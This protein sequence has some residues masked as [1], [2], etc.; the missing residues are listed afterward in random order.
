MFLI[1]EVCCPLPDYTPAM[2]GGSLQR[3]DLIAEYFAQGFTYKDILVAL[4][5]SHGIAISLK[6]LKRT[7]RSLRLRR[8]QFLSREEIVSAIDEI[9]TELS[10][11]GQCIGYRSMWK[12]LQNKGLVV[13]AH[14]VREILKFLD[15]EGV[16]GR[17]IGRLKRRDY[18]NPG[19]N[20][21]WHI[22][23]YD[24]LKPFG[25][26][27]HGAIDGYSRRILWVELGISN[28]NPKVILKYFVD[29]IKKLKTIPCIIRSDRGT[30]NIHVQD[31]QQTLRAHDGDEFCNK[32]F[33]YGKSSSNQRIEAWWRILRQQSMG[34]Y[35][36]LF[37]DMVCQGI[38]DTGNQL[39][40]HSLRFAFWD[41]I[42]SDLNR[43]AIEWNRHRLQ[44][45]K[46]TKELRV[47]PTC[48]TL[49]LKLIRQQ[50]VVF[51]AIQT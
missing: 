26:A 38:L 44:V 39:H 36:N 45:K 34:F 22:D 51:F 47:F 32:A 13:S 46:T 28:N 24:K 2:C 12:R 11:S 25:F 6:T 33:L 42:E 18:V 16:R 30:E 4:L 17:R 31:L 23:G 50:I 35:I 40:I 49:I 41:L 19:P 27:I 14:T 7:L 1:G 15:G 48:C 5:V 3:D 10:G 20:F 37:K 9:R 29:T 21:V 8:R 43:T